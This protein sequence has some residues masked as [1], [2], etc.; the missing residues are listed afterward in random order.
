[1]SNQ[2]PNFEK[3]PIYLGILK[4][5]TLTSKAYVQFFCESENYTQCKRFMVKK[6]TGVCPPDLLPNSVL[7]V[8]EIVAKYSLSKV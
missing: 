3:C 8:E 4:G 5:K 1:M 7:T 2:C 6:A